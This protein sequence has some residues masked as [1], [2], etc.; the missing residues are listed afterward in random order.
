MMRL[1]LR[2]AVALATLAPLSGCLLEPGPEKLNQDVSADYWQTLDDSLSL[3]APDNQEE[4]SS[5]PVATGL[6]SDMTPLYGELYEPIDNWWNVKIKDA[7]VDPNSDAII[8]TI[9][10]YDANGGRLHPDFAADWGIPY[11]VVDESTPLVPVDF[12]YASESDPGAPGA[13]AGYPIPAEAITNPRYIESE[14]SSSGDR[15]LLIFDRDRRLAFELARASYS[16]GEWSASCGA[17]FKLDVNH[18]RPQG[19]TSADAAGLCVLAGL[20]RFDEM[21]G[22]WPIRHALRVSIR[23]TNGHVWPASHTGATDAGAPPLG[24]RLRLKKH[25]DTKQ[26]PLHLRKIFTVM[27]VYGLIVADRGGNMYVQGTMDDRWD[28]GV[29]NPIFHSLK[30]TD[31]EVIEL[32]WNP[33]EDQ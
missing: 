30:V 12:G 5:R 3:A 24:M 16:N 17:V 9:A 26:Y 23:R 32:G 4:F 25:V 27:K 7:P 20:V 29:I 22:P 10:G 21:F 13:P 15:H 6:L 14:G 28:N 19:W 8:A 18:R 1:A 11:V 31:F 2:A 33:N